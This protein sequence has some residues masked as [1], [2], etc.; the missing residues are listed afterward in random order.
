MFHDL[1][2]RNRQKSYSTFPIKWDPISTLSSKEKHQIFPF[3][4]IPISSRITLQ[5][6]G[7][8]PISQHFSKMFTKWREN[9]AN[10]QKLNS[11][12]LLKTFSTGRFS[13]P[14]GFS[15]WS[16]YQSWF[17]VSTPNSVIYKPTPSAVPKRTPVHICCQTR[18]T[19]SWFHSSWS[20]T[21]NSWFE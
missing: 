2:S 4:R 18:R 15:A 14:V 10:L 11:F 21:F 3:Y 12:Q 1:R 8:V 16:R 13:L 19:R 6:F 20:L 9:P 5:G 7:E 17:G